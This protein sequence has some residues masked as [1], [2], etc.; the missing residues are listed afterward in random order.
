MR[1][2]IIIGVISLL[3]CIVIGFG[4]KAYVSHQPGLVSM[5]LR[6][7]FIHDQGNCWMVWLPDLAKWADNTEWKEYS[8]LMIYEN[9]RALGPAHS[10]HDSIRIMG[11]R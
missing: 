7:P 11:R 5:Q 2:L 4:Y 8:T 9:G 10:F 6:P 3:L 1:R